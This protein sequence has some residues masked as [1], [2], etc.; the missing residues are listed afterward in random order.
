MT[1]NQE[2]RTLRTKVRRSSHISREHR[3][4]R[5]K[6]KFVW[7]AFH[8]TF[9]M[10]TYATILP[11]LILGL[12]GNRMHHYRL[13]SFT[14]ASAAHITRPDAKSCTRDHHDVVPSLNAFRI[15]SKSWPLRGPIFAS[16]FINLIDKRRFSSEMTVCF[17]M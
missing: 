13:P 1:A 9:T 14:P 15:V 6:K 8:E 16:L 17:G 4:S 11:Y 5:L 3:A 7:Y 10:P 2:P 12:L